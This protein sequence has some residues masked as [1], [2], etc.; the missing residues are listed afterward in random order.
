MIEEMVAKVFCARNYSQVAH[1]K[2]KSYAEH[3]ALGHFYKDIACL[4]DRLVEAYQ[5]AFEI[6][7]NVKYVEP[8]SKSILTYLQTEAVWLSKNRSKIAKEVPTLEAIVD[9]IIELYLTT[10]YKIENLK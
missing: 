10:I 3:K 6:I 8:D 2:S 1:W 7:G 4:V 5:G 9:D